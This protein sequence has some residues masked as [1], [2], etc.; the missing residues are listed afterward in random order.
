[1]SGQGITYSQAIALAK[2]A[3]KNGE[4][5]V[6]IPQALGESADD[7]EGAGSGGGNQAR[8]NSQASGGVDGEGRRNGAP[9]KVRS[10]KRG[11]AA[12][13][14]TKAKVVSRKPS[15]AAKP[16]PKAKKPAKRHR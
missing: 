1:M 11:A 7:A 4:R 8:I 14:K 10:V 6:V 13:K 16:K 15:R 9:P 5:E 2:A 3:A 12:K